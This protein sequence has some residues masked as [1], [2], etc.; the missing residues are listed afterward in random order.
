MASCQCCIRVELGIPSQFRRGRRGGSAAVTLH[1]KFVVLVVR[2]VSWHRRRHGDSHL[3]DD[4]GDDDGGQGR[5]TRAAIAGYP[6]N[7]PGGT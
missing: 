5:P 6:R 7:V 1:F 4:D 3:D 2:R